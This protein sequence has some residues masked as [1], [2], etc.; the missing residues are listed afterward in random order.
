MKLRPIGLSIDQPTKN[1]IVPINDYTSGTK[2][3]AE[4][5]R[6]DLTCY[7][8]CRT[9]GRF[10][11]ATLMETGGYCSPVCAMSFAQC[12]TCGRY[13]PRE[14]LKERYFCSQDCSIQYRFLKT[15]G[16]RPVVIA[17]DQTL[18]DPDDLLL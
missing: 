15:M 17:S 11:T 4:E 1:R 8:V 9:C 18:N 10:L 13:V 16:P 14:E 12:I 2:K 6:K 3:M 7:G 5:I